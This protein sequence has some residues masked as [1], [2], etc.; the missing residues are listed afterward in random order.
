MFLGAEVKS[1]NEEGT[2]EVVASSGK[3]DRLGDTIDPKGWV[4]TNYKKNPVM[5][6][7]HNSYELPIAKA[8][9]IWVE[10]EKELKLQ[11]QFA[12]TDFAQQVKTLVQNGFLNAVSVGF[13]P[14]VEDE[15]GNIEYEGKT[16][17]HALEEEIKEVNEKGFWG[18][19]QHF[20]KQELLE[21]S[22][23][24]VPALASALVTSRKMNLA[25]ATKALEGIEAEEKEKEE[26]EKELEENKAKEDSQFETRLSELEKAIS[27]LREA[28]VSEKETTPSEDNKG[29]TQNIKQKSNHERLLIMFDK[30]CELLLIELRQHNK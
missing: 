10:D 25:L 9:K 16:Y 3:V 4:L 2:F 14:L 7:A 30:F 6:W 5:L 17:R 29:R 1:V 11:G 20:T 19:G 12:E 15:K 8:T 27:L 21:V 22:W 26:K 13:M 18:E 28:K 23:V 24:N